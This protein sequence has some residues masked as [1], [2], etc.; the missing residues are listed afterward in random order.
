MPLPPPPP[1]Q[2]SSDGGSG[3][4][5]TTRIGA[6]CP[7]DEGQKQDGRGIETS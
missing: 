3:L 2:P 1:A 4:Q 6:N 5:L 7:V